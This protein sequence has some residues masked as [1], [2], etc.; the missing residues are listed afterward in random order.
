VFLGKLVIESTL[1][2]VCEGEGG[3]AND[4]GGRGVAYFLALEISVEGIKEK[5]VVRDG[6]PV[7]N[8]LFLLSA[9]ALVLE[10][11]IKEERLCMAEKKKKKIETKGAYLGFLERGIIARL[12]VTEV[13]EDTLLELFHILDRTAEC[14]GLDEEDV[15]GER[16]ERADLETK[17]KGTDDV[18]ASDVVKTIPEDTGDKLLGGEEETVEGEVGCMCVTVRWRRPA[19]ATADGERQGLRSCAGPLGG[20]RGKE[21]FE[22]VQMGKLFLLLA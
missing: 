11:E 20:R 6:V 7:K 13:A 15:G 21:E 14:L 19:G 12:E 5:T 1:W 2:I 3:F 9:D 10:E 4:V 16:D 18:C 17:D 8:L 22:A